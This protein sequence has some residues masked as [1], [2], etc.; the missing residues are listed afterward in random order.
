[1]SQNIDPNI[2]EVKDIFLDAEAEYLNKIKK[3][4]ENDFGLQK[5]F[6]LLRRESPEW[7]FKQA[8]QRM[9]KIETWEIPYDKIEI[10]E[11][12]IVILLD[13]ISD[14]FKDQIEVAKKS[15]SQP[16]LTNKER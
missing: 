16:N 2:T 11:R 6:R 1:M 4:T 12:Q 3:E 10:V 13:S 9:E 5:L 15:P 14:I 8:L 7:L